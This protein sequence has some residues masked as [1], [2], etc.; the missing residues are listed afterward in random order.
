MAQAEEQKKDDKKTYIATWKGVVIAES[1][2]TVEVEG[3]QY[4][5]VDSIVEKYY[6][7]TDHTTVCGWKGT[8]NY[9]SIVIDKDEN[10]NACWY[11]AKPKDAAKQISGRVAFWKGVQVSCK[12]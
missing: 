5:P 4:F 11:Y 12:K 6:K 7:K 8:A 9:Y 2:D 1:S 10:K 3:N